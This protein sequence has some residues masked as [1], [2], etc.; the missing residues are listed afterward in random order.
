MSETKN[1]AVKTE[2]VKRAQAKSTSKSQ[3][4]RVEVTLSK[5]SKYA[6]KGTKFNV[7]PT[8]AEIFKAKGLL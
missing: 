8:V 6:K 3:L 5:D 4:D 1:K 7:H 2:A